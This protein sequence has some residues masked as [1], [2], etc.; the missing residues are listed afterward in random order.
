M[1]R[2]TNILIECGS[3]HELPSLEEKLNREFRLCDMTKH[4]KTL[5]I[6]V[7]ACGYRFSLKQLRVAVASAKVKM[8]DYEVVN[9]KTQRTY[10]DFSA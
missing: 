1:Y 5:L 8:F 7:P 3:K 9:G 2:G 6:P 10:Y 4:G